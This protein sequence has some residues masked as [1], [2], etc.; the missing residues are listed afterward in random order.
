MD[1]AFVMEQVAKAP[2]QFDITP[3]NPDRRVTMGGGHMCF[4]NVSSPPNAMDLDNGR[5]VGNTDDFRNFMRLT[6]YFNCIHVAGG[7]RWSWWISRQRAP[8][9]PVRQ[10]DRPT[11]APSA[12]PRASRT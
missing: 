12:S 7:Y 9:L 2:R 3:R 4:V 11:G 1:R 8:R 10:A 5:R 6:Q